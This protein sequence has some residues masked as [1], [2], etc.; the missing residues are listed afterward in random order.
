MN[1]DEYYAKY[2]TLIS[3]ESERLFVDEFLF[4]LLGSNIE[5]VI[6]Q[7]PFI[8]RTGKSR[9]IDFVCRFG[10]SYLALEVNGETYHAEGIIPNEQFDDN[11]F[12]QNE[13]LRMGYRLLRFSYS[14]LQ[15]QIWRPVV[16]DALRE[17][18]SESAA[19]LLG[20]YQLD[21]NPIQIEA[22]E[23][24]EFRRSI[25]WKKCVVVLPTGTGKTILSAIDSRNHG[26]RVLFLVH[27]LDIL[28]QSID[29]FK[30]AWGN[31]E[32]GILTGEVKENV[33]TPDVLFASKDTLRNPNILADYPEDWFD[34]I[35]VDEVHHGQTPSYRELLK[36]FKPKFMLGMTAT[37]DRTDRKDIFELFDYNKAYELSLQDAIDR[38]FLVPY[39]YYGLTD[40]IDYSNI[41]MSGN[42]YRV[43]DL[44]RNLIIPERNKAILDE[45]LGK[46]GGDKAVG[47]CVSIKHADRMAE[48]FIENGLSAVAIHSESDNRDDLIHDFRNDQYQIVF[49]VDLFNEGVDFPNLR[50]LLFLRPTESK[51]VFTQQLGRGL[52]LSS[53]KDRVRVLDFIGNYK[54]ANQIRK[55]LAKKTSHDPNAPKNNGLKKLEYEYSN[56][57]EVIFSSEVEEI[58]DRQDSD[59]LGI[60]RND[61]KDAYFELAEK[62]QSKPSQADLDESGLYKASAYIRM[63]GS[64]TKFLR[65]VGEFTEA[66]YHYPQGTHMGHV[67]SILAGFSRETRIGTQFDDQFI[68]MRGGL[69]SGR[70][71]N[72]QRQ[73]KYKLQAAMELGL[74]EDDRVYQG[75]DQFIPSLTRSGQEIAKIFSRFWSESELEFPTDES[76]VPSSSM[77]KS[78]TDYN[79]IVLSAVESNSKNKSSILDVFLSMPAVRQMMYYLYCV[80]RSS[81]V[82][83]SQIYEDFFRSPHVARFCDREGIEPAT[84]EA[85]RRRCPFLLNILASIGVTENYTS[86]VEVVKLLMI[87]DLVKA[88]ESEEDTTAIARMRALKTALK[89]G[90]D[91]LEPSD[92]SI[93]R[94]SLGGDF[95][96]DNYHLNNTEF[97]E[98]RNR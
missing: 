92:L 64:W 62:L 96:T 67:L 42:K 12:R 72:Y 29:A 21:P 78:E 69:N 60:N 39:T 77:A 36:S 3:Q 95:L 97:Y 26:G 23:E 87:P 24:L 43:D 35:I 68:K 7:Y 53:G 4:P 81:K 20:E 94:E 51:T 90:S 58:L 48:Y 14:Q 5:H 66:S 70:I 22:L 37:P 76:G 84:I 25:G 74:L 49:T 32:V 38:G 47:F 13:I 8:D 16:A 55:Y 75:N 61:L 1:L 79:R 57:C 85:S 18:F 28:K 2:G 54:R 56:G 50:V 59:E 46:G 41:R 34:Y 65:E 63:F 82:E 40:D 73:V 44:E 27:R 33:H 6:P 31:I 86:H 15:S 17:A 19:D 9:K 98:F 10:S 88:T 52:R 71:G 93:A 45:Y 80:A 11:L 83:K 91:S 30:L 89:S